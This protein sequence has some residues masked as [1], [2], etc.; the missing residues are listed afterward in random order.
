[1]ALVALDLPSPRQLRGGWAALAAIYASRGWDD[2]AAT[3]NE[4]RFHD[5]GGNW[6][7]LRF[8]DG[9]RAV[10]LGHDHE[11][12]ETYFGDAAAYFGEDETD[13]L[14]EA[15]AWWSHDLSTG[16]HS[17]WI[18][19]IYGWDGET[20]RRSAYQQDDGFRSVG[21]LQAGSLDTLT[22]F[23]RDAPGLD[24]EPD[25]MALAA[26]VAADADLTPAVMEAVVPGWDVAAGVAAG[27]RFLLRRT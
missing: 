12:S 24:G 16:R 21:L 3:E 7:T 5:G 25:P 18:G 6:A 19:F 9:G 22:A 17:D 8:Q 23:S 4:W 11:Y 27:R 1:M 10:L 26:L 2:V 15:P 20:W 13:L 14:A